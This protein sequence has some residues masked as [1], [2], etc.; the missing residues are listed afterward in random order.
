MYGTM[1]GLETKLPSRDFIRVHRKYIVRLD[2]I[3]A[4]KTNAAVLDSGLPTATNQ[5]P[6]RVTIGSS[7][8]AGLLARLNMI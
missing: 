6:V 2:C 3:S 5:A 4:I 8:K 7:Y 1:K